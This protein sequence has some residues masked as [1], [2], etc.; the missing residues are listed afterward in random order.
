MSGHPETKEQSHHRDCRKNTVSRPTAPA[1][2]P[3]KAPCK[4]KKNAERGI[5]GNQ[6]ADQMQW[7]SNEDGI[8]YDTQTVNKLDYGNQHCA[9][10]WSQLATQTH[11]EYAKQCSEGK[12]VGLLQQF[13]G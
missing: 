1:R 11:C 7:R 5:E 3:S 8:A 12:E 13:E 10:S 6:I 2:I 4:K 9:K